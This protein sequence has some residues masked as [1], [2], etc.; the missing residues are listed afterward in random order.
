MSKALE[1]IIRAHPT[2]ALSATV[3]LLVI[4]GYAESRV[5]T[6]KPGI[7]CFTWAWALL[8][9]AGLAG[10]VLGT[11]GWVLAGMIMVGG[12]LLIAK[13]YERHRA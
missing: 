8:V 5:Y 10:Q 2:L 11:F 3:L 13:Y 4:V 6:T 7:A 12:T 9:L 1:S